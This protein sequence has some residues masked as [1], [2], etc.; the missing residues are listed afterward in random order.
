MLK[1]A[2]LAT[3]LLVAASTG[4]VEGAASDLAA[5]PAPAAPCVPGASP[6]LGCTL[7]ASDVNGDST[8]SAA[9]LGNLAVPAAPGVDWPSLHPAPEAG[10]NFKDAATEPV[11][12]LPASL[13][14]ESSHP[15]VPAVFALGALVILL[16]R[17]PNR[18]GPRG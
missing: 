12:V 13:D 1:V 11:S 6:V 2:L 3:G 15:L 9:E 17:R 5:A 16:R 10:L 7:R 18:A 8:T 14:R 4:A